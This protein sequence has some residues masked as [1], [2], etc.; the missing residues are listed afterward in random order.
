MLYVNVFKKNDKRTIYNV[1]Y[2][3]G[4]VGPSYVKRF[5]VTGT[6]RDK[7]YNL[8]KGTQ[9]SRVL[10]F[11]ANPNGEAEGDQGMPETETGHEETGVRV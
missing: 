1:A 7:Q 5:F 8:T 3:D 11:S 2:R 4:K 6:T 10:Y 9:G